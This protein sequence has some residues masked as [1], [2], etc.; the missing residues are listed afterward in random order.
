M[1]LSSAID[2]AVKAYAD[3]TEVVLAGD[4]TLDVSSLLQ[5]FNQISQFTQQFPPNFLG[6]YGAA[7]NGT[8]APVASMGPDGVKPKQKRQ[9]KQRD[10]NAPKRPL[11]A[12]FR[13]LREQR[14][15]I[16]KEMA[17]NPAADGSKAGDISKTATERWKALTDAERE[18]YKQAYQKELLKYESDTKA[19][20]DSLKAEGI[21]P[22]DDEDADAEDE[23]QDAV[24]APVVARADDDDDSET[25]SDSSSDEDDSSSEEE[26]EVIKQPSPP[27]KK[28][29][30]A[31]AAPKK[32]TAGPDPVPQPQ[33]FSSLNPVLPSSSAAA[34]VESAK[35]R[36]NAGAT[37]GEE[38]T[39]KKRVR[40]TKAEIEAADAAAAA[41]QLIQ[42]EATPGA[43]KKIKKE[44]KKRK[45]EAAGAAA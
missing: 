13:Y 30:K 41:A 2:R 29:A 10:L 7:P 32:I 33:M 24:A 27:P 3:H 15:I 44:K 12:Y 20:K 16:T 40:R 31:A 5:P 34:P 35:K 37:D 21:K 22:E 6:Q 4:G 39:K 38:S 1:S 8:A 45:S 42:A 25:D 9:Y 17:E 43:E 36:K 14:P 11:T 19:Y 28:K 23:F 26:V 18:P